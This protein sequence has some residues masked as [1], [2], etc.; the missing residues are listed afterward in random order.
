MVKKTIEIPIEVYK[1]L[2]NEHLIN[3]TS[4]TTQIERD[5]LIEAYIQVMQERYWEE[6][7]V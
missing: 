7:D 5:K 3:Q 6:E 4:E 2:I 1:G